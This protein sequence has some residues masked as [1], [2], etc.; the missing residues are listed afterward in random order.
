MDREG[1]IPDIG[2]KQ[3]LVQMHN[4]AG[5]WMVPQGRTTADHRGVIRG[6]PA[7]DRGSH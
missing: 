1:L 2:F 4:L 6:R 5:L 7:G 3:S